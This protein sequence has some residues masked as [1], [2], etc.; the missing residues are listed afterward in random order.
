[1][2]HE[3]EHGGAG[4]VVA[5][6]LG[7]LAGAVVALLFA[8]AKGEDTR[9]LLTEKAREGRDKVKEYV[10]DLVEKKLFT[11]YIDWNDGELI[12]I[13]AAKIETNKCPRCGGELEL[14]GKGVVECPYCG[15]EIF[16]S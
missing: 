6:A 7:A 3:R 1:M 13:D 9:D 5:F 4:I 8:P 14:A 15:T 10:Y 11:G 16:L 12:S 2:A